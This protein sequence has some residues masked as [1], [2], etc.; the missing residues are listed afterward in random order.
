MA[1]SNQGVAFR[2]PPKALASEQAQLN[3]FDWYAEM[4]REHPVRYDDQRGRWDVFKYEDVKQIVSDHETYAS[5]VAS[6]DIRLVDRDFDTDRAP[7]MIRA[8]PPAHG[9]LRNFVNSRFQ[10]GS[11]AEHRARFEQIA[12]DLLDDIDS[13]A[14]VDIIDKFSHP[15]PVTIIADLLGLP[16]DDYDQFLTWSKAATELSLTG[17]EKA[18][19]S[20]KRRRAR[21]QREMREYFSNLISERATGSGDDLITLAA[22]ND[23]LTHEEKISFCL[24]LLIAG[25][26]TTVNLITNALWCFEEN[27]LFDAVRTG[28]V[29]RTKVIEEVLRYRSPAQTVRRVTTKPVELGGRRI[30]A[31]EL[32]LA[33]VGS[34]NRDPA[35]FDSPEEFRPERSPNPHIA[36][37]G[38]I[39]FCLGAQLARLEADIALEKLLDRF[40]VINP[41]L[42]DLSPQ[43]FLY[44]VKSF[45]CRLETGN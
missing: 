29:S 27:D 3:P 11:I 12:D 2:T 16:R 21:V 10:P 42:S 41:D 32:V 39:H 45:P 34:A 14:N 31:G 35:R 30:D 19:E 44:G 40:E 33:R 38:G 5:D 23:G 9:R 4:R 1:S 15:Y 18:I 28:A 36:F 43:T 25:N 26:V 24:T 17:D 8:D 37:G 6:T 7:S 20:N 13:G 22:M